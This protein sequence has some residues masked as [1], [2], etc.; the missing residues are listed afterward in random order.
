MSKQRLSVTIDSELLEHLDSQVGKRK[1]FPTRSAATEAAIR[2]S[3]RLQRRK[4]MAAY[5]AEQ[6]EEDRADDLA[7]GR[8]GAEILAKRYKSEYGE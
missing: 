6:S 8:A 3:L 1:P 7:W 5:Y 2:V 4:E